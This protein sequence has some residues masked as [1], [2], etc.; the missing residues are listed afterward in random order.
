MNDRDRLIAYMWLQHDLLN[1][2]GKCIYF[3]IE[4]EDE[5]YNWSE[6]DI[7]KVWKWTKKYK[8]FPFCIYLSFYDSVN[9]EFNGLM[10]GYGNRHGNCFNDKNNE[11]S[12]SMNVFMKNF[13]HKYSE[14][15]E[16]CIK[17]IEEV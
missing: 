11:S 1:I 10:C 12:K 4:D 5:I 16:Y 15:C 3:T 17:E 13:E 2:F 8:T 14:F 7:K 6:K 9:C